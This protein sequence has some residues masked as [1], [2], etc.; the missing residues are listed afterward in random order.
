MEGRIPSRHKPTTTTARFIFPG[1]I[2]AF[3][4]STAGYNLF[5]NLLSTSTFTSTVLSTVSSTLTIATIQSCVAAAQFASGRS[6]I[7]CRRRRSSTE[8]LVKPSQVQS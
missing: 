7:P 4:H 2:Y 5:K 6:T 3:S 1:Q 8:I